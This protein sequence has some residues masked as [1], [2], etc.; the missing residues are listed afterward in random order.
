MSESWLQGQL[1]RHSE[2]FRCAICDVPSRGPAYETM[3]GLAHSWSDWN[4]PGDLFRC[5]DCGRY[6]CA[7]H[8]A[9]D[10]GSCRECQGRR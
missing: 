2:R 1:S 4:R 5:R 6:V 3:D 7:E 10:R 9:P 8:Y